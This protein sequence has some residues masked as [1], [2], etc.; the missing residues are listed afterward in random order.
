MSECGPR[1]DSPYNKDKQN[2]TGHMECQSLQS[3]TNGITILRC[4][5]IS[6]MVIVAL[7]C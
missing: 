2:G 5:L 6:A 4:F 1:T 7:E 3:M